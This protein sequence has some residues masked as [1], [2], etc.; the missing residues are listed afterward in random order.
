MREDMITT[1]AQM[2]GT[3]TTVVT[4]PPCE[5][6]LVYQNVGTI[7]NIPVSG[8]GQPEIDDHQ[9]AFFTTRDDSVYNSFE[10][11]TTEME[12]K[13][14]VLEGKKKDI[15]GSN[16]FGL[17]TTDMCL[18][19]GVKIP[20]KF[21]F[22]NFEKYK[23]VSCPKTHIR[24]FCRKMAADSKDEKLLMH[25]FQDSLSGDSLEWYMELERIHIQTW[26]ELAK[27]FLKHYQ[28]NSDMAHNRTQLQ[29]LTQKSDESFKEY[30]Q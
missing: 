9:N 8:R 4:H 14:H 24:S 27:A 23:G 17:D 29:S 13:L 18:V 5:G 16:A 30:A 3:V 1:R 26:R 19:P 20:A 22:L 10:P 25:F 28:Y 21:K 7:F 12:T 11:S 2:G 15:K 6:G